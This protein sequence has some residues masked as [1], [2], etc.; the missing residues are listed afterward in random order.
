VSTRG[1]SRQPPQVSKFSHY[2]TSIWIFTDAL[3]VSLVVAHVV[4]HF[5]QL[6]VL[7]RGAF[8]SFLC[9]SE[10]AFDI[11]DLFFE[12]L[13]KIVHLTTCTV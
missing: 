4:Q 5:M 13:D 7:F 10:V 2:K 9:S 6:S 8:C 11:R 1:L 12:C 3:P